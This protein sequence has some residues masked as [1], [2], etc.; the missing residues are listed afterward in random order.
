MKYTNVPLSLSCIHKHCLHEQNKGN[1]LRVFKSP[2][3]GQKCCG[4]LDS[5]YLQ[6]K[7]LCFSLVSES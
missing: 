1:V 6:L 7:S 5:L 2:I 3:N 4:H